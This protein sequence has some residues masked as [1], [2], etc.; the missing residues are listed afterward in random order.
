MSLWKKPGRSA[1]LKVPT[2]A[3]SGRRRPRAWRAFQ[4]RRLQLEPLED[5]C[6]LSVATVNTALDVVDLG[7]GV[8]SLREAILITNILEG[9]DTIQFAESLHGQ[10]INLSAGQLTITDDLTIAGP[11]GNLIVIDAT[12]GDD[13]P[14]LNDGQGSR[15]FNI[16][17]GDGLN[18]IEVNISGVVLTGG[19]AEGNGGAILHVESLTLNDVNISGNNATG[20]GGGVYNENGLLTI[21]RS[22]FL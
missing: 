7:D 3:R 15:I 10:T 11:G 14:D 6:M 16:N 12:A 21:A 18:T 8:T 22:N 17:D 2:F 5:R 13:T 9:H 1:S 4:G 19:D 20:N